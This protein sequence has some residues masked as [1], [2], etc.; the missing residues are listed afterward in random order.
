MLKRID[1]GNHHSAACGDPLRNAEELNEKL[2]LAP[3]ASNVVLFPH[4]PQLPSRSR[5]V[6]GVDELALLEAENALL[7]NSV[8]DLA[9]EI[10]ELRGT[11]RTAA[12]TYVV[13]RRSRFRG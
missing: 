2:R 9:L 1:Q 5:G 8:I 10:Q 11:V 12:K 13:I 4:R 3:N 6:G 7:R